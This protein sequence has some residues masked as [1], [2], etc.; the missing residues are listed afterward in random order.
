V[1]M[2]FVRLRSESEG[3]PPIPA[4]EETRAAAMRLSFIMFRVIM[5]ACFFFVLCMRGSKRKIMSIEWVGEGREGA[6]CSSE[7][8]VGRNRFGCSRVLRLVF[9]MRRFHIFFSTHS[10]SPLRSLRDPFSSLDAFKMVR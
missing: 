7:R 10:N 8:G 3:G 9:A 1:A 4:D 6:E 2:L 5:I